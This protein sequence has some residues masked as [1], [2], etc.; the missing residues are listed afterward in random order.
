MTAVSHDPGA[1]SLTDVSWLVRNG[2]A[3]NAPRADAPAGSQPRAEIAPALDSWTPADDGRH[4]P[5]S[6]RRRVLPWA[7]AVAAAVVLVAGVLSD[8][9]TRSELRQARSSLASTRARLVSTQ[10]KLS[11]TLASLRQVQAGLGSV[12]GQRDVLQ[13]ELR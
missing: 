13:V 3:P 8:L 2:R 4:Q 9:Q 5:P 11:S 6:P 12:S 1:M 10:S 7:A